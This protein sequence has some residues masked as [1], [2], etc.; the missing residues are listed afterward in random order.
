M[1]CSAYGGTVIGGT[2]FDDHNV[3]H[4]IQSD[5]AGRYY[6]ENGNRIPIDGISAAPIEWDGYGYILIT[7]TGG[8]NYVEGPQEVLVQITNALKSAKN[9]TQKLVKVNSTSPQPKL[10]IAKGSITIPKPFHAGLG[11][12]KNSNN[13]SSHMRTGYPGSFISKH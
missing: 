1:A 2:Y 9:N 13:T 5:G 8:G 6:F 11:G 7:P 12:M 10:T 4:A 3:K